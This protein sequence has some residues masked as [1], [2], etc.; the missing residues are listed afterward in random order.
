MLINHGG[1]THVL[2]PSRQFAALAAIVLLL[3]THAAHTADE[4]LSAAPVKT[5]EEAV[6][7]G[8]IKQASVDM[9]VKQ[10][11]AAVIV[12]LRLPRAL[13][14]EGE[15]TDAE[16]TAQRGAIRKAQDEVLAAVGSAKVSAMWRY[17]YIPHV[18]L[19]ADTAALT[20]LVA[21][22]AVLLVAEDRLGKMTLPATLPYIGMLPVDRVFRTTSGGAGFSVAVL[23]SGVDPTHPAFT[24]KIIAEACFGTNGPV[25]GGGTARSIC[26]GGAEVSTDAGSAVPCNGLGCDH[27]TGMAG[28][29]AGRPVQG[30]DIRGIAPDASIIAIQVM[31]EVSGTPGCTDNPCGA[32]QERDVARALEHVQSLSGTHRIAAV[33]ISTLFGTAMRPNE[34]CDDDFPL[35]R[36]AV[37]NLRSFGIP[38]V[39]SAGN[40]GRSAAFLVAPACISTVMSVGYTKRFPLPEEVG[41]ASSSAS[42]LTMLA[43]AAPLTF[44]TTMPQRFKSLPDAGTSGAAALVS[45]VWAVVRSAVPNRSFIEYFNALATSGP[46]I[47]DPR[48][49]VTKYRLQ[50]DAAIEMLTGRPLTPSAVNA[51]TNLS[52]QLTVSWTDNSYLE[53]LFV[54]RATPPPRSGLPARRVNVVANTQQTTITGLHSNT[55]YTIVVSACDFYGGCTDSGP[56][57]ARTAD[58]LAS[59]PTNLRVEAVDLRAGTARV[60]WEASSTPSRPITYFLFEQRHDGI[61]NIRIDDPARRDFEFTGLQLFNTYE[62]RVWACNTDDC[63]DDSSNSVRVDMREI[64][65]PPAAP[66][67][68]HPCV[69]ARLGACFPPIDLRWTN[70]A[71]DA[72]WFEFQWSLLP[73]IPPYRSWTTI[74]L[75]GPNF[76]RYVWNDYNPNSAYA[77]RVRACNFAG[78]SVWSNELFH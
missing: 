34:P 14:A 58:K 19:H 32:P 42:Y 35:T 51:T 12:A 50:V 33:N 63:S 15:L 61:S 1:C 57:M 48:N 46:P 13:R 36:D 74:R 62:Y 9:A 77:F 30:S 21:S 53:Y 20:A 11:R 22:P 55:P 43:P 69:G 5:L 37:N 41:V 2:H 78:C 72:R 70:N 10:G 76:S 27:G 6:R 24:G 28:I 17:Q 40:D 45:G 64:G 44:H 8:R 49:G 4:P 68:L 16:V 23:D 59:A 38:V 26:P 25:V 73:T 29:A 56:F 71:T 3:V 54:V 52:K 65:P 39:A 75:D 47:Q 31:T 60:R 66:T 18:A 67:D 7:S